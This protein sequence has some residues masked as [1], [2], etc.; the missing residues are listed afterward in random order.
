MA[1]VPAEPTPP[2]RCPT[3]RPALIARVNQ[4]RAA[5]ARLRRQHVRP[6][7]RAHLEYQLAQAATAHSLDMVTNNFF[8]HGSS[9]GSTL[10]SRVAATGYVAE[11]P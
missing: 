8:D 4:L 10:G 11:A 7:R 1:P 5:G 9:N 2:A 3:S 6:G